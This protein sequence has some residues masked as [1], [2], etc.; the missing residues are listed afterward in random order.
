MEH[1]FYW[2]SAKIITD[3]IYGILWKL[4]FT[5]EMILFPFSVQIILDYKSFNFQ[6]NVKGVADHFL[7]KNMKENLVWWKTV[8]FWLLF[9]LISLL[10]SLF[11]FWTTINLYNK[12]TLPSIK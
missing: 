1:N 8:V 11:Q 2:F 5:F 6:D 3:P 7:D 12:H 10:L 9:L 4:W